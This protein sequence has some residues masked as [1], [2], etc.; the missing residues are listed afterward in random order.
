[1][2]EWKGGDMNAQDGCCG[3]VQ[4]GKNGYLVVGVTYLQQLTDC[5]GT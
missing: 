5:R 3:M 2:R 1:M 4:D